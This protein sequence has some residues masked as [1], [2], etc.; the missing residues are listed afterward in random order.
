MQ[1]LAAGAGLA[2]RK[3]D[4]IV[5]NDIKPYEAGGFK[6]AVAQ[7][8]VT[9]LMTI[10]EHLENL[11]GALEALRQSRGLDFALLLITDIVRNS[12]RIL[13]ANPHP[14]LDDLPYP[15]LPD[16]TR[17]APGVVSRKK[18]LLP[19]LLGLLEK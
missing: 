2:N 4:E 5:S 6:F 18:Q 1:I 10:N 3:P 15:P 8:E 9:D 14:I 7:A 16:G 13:I 17:D 12:S 11:Q 19:A